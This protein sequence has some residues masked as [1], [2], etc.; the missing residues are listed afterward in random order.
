M[1]PELYRMA[2]KPQPLTVR[3]REDFAPPTA[4]P[5]PDVVAV[6]RA[7]ECHV[8]PPDVA[9]RMVEAL[10]DV[11]DGMTLEPSAGTGALSRA[12]LE[13]GQ[14]PRLLVQIERHHALAATL[15]PFGTVMQSCFL[16]WAEEAR[17][18]VTFPRIIMNPPFRHVRQHVRAARSL[19]GSGRHACAPVLVAL[20]PI[21]FDNDG[22]ETLEEL[23]AETFAAARV[24]TK[25]IRY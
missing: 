15:E 1:R 20:V 21:T 23:D 3:R 25:V 22:A 18:V 2:R 4:K 5:L 19:L 9:R 13:A 16:E 10:G 11:R 12:L 17:G 8:T 7:T 24:R 6:D 14:D